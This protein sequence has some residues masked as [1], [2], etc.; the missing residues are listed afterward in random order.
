MY[1]RGAGTDLKVFCNPGAKFNEV[2]RL[3]RPR[4]RVVTVIIA[5]GNDVDMQRSSKEIVDSMKIEEIKAE[6]TRR[7]GFVVWVELFPRFD[8]GE[9]FNRKVREVSKRMGKKFIRRRT[10]GRNV[11]I[12]RSK[13]LGRENFGNDGIHLNDTGKSRLADKLY[14]LNDQ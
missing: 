1:R 3:A 13:H 4:R 10:A 12:L 2:V 5:G 6:A 9:A 14:W 7:N 11:A 8:Q